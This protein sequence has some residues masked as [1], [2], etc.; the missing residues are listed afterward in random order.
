MVAHLS[1]EARCTQNP[2]TPAVQ[3]S[4]AIAPALPGQRKALGLGILG[5]WS[6]ETSSGIRLWYVAGGG[7]AWSSLTKSENVCNDIGTW[8]SHSHECNGNF[9]G[10]AC[11][12]ITSFSGIP[13]IGVVTSFVSSATPT[14]SV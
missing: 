3:V 13:S 14:K 8:S 7:V 5:S 9:D 12:T 6:S 2:L 10:T 1:F 11:G 4:V